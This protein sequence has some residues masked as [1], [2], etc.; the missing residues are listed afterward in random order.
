MRERNGVRMGQRV[1]NVD[2]KSLGRVVG[3]YD[4]GFAVR[5]GLPVLWRR[6]FVLRYDEVRGVRDGALVAA[7]SSRDL[8]ELAAGDVP[9]SWRI[10]TPSEYP[11]IATPA[12]AHALVAAVARGHVPGVS[13]AAEPAELPAATAPVTE[14]EVRAFADTRGESLEP[15]ETDRR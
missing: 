15:A 4:W 11:A 9:P 12:E 5:W 10:R 14:P 3:L 2:G 1:V 8:D 6:D 7:R 13:P